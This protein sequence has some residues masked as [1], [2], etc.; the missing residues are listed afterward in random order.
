MKVFVRLADGRAGE[1]FLKR[2]LSWLPLENDNDQVL[3]THGG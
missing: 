3:E 1:G 2:W